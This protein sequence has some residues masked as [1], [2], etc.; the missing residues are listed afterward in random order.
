M[1]QPVERAL[2]SD[3]IYDVLRSRIVTVQILPGHRLDIAKLAAGF[4]TSAIPVREALKRLTE[5]GLVTSMPGIGYRVTSYSASDIADILDFRKALEL[6]ALDDSAARLPAELLLDLAG[7]NEE[8]FSMSDR[9]NAHEIP[10]PVD[11]RL[12]S[13]C[14]VGYA[15]NR[16]LKETYDRLNDRISVARHLVHRYPDVISEHRE[17]IRLLLKRDTTGALRALDEHLNMTAIECIRAVE[18]GWTPVPI[19]TGNSDQERFSRED[20]LGGDA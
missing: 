8:L 9:L 11:Y 17:I 1:R 13:E 20:T 5:R 15:R 16:Y 14:I 10:D 7:A 4:E 18:A 12:H 3:Q 6:L 19:R 2:L